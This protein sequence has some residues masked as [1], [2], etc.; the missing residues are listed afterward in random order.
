MRPRVRGV[1]S[2]EVCVR[3]SRPPRGGSGIS[4]PVPAGPQY[5]WTFKTW[6]KR[7]QTDYHDRESHHEQDVCV[8]TVIAG[9][10][11]AAKAKIESALPPLPVDLSDWRPHSYTR[12]WELQGTVEEVS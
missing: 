4:S 1:M 2:P 5:R 7:T 9:T 12:E 3:P 6:V 8:M 11:S 10:E